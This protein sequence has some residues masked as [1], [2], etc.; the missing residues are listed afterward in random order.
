MY[1]VQ[2]IQDEELQKETIIFNVTDKNYYSSD[3]VTLEELTV[4]MDG[5]QIDDQ[6]TKELI[7]TVE[8]K[9]N[10]DGEVKVVGHQYTLEI[11]Q[12]VETD[13]EFIGSGRDYRE[14]SGT[15]EVRIDP[16]ASR[17]IRGNK[18]NDETTTITD[19]LTL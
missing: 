15:L 14:L 13:E 16:N 17:D 18:L 9:A 10:I 1:D 5:V 7:S 6:I 3:P 4:W 2:K 11:T 12:I 8:I 19:L